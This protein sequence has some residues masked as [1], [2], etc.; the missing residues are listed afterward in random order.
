MSEAPEESVLTDADESP[1]S[2]QVRVP[3]FCQRKILVA[4]VG[5]LAAIVVGVSLAYQAALARV[6]DTTGLPPSEAE[7]ALVDLVS[8]V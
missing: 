3:W 6:P 2:S 1:G 4:A 5:A 8:R 7:A